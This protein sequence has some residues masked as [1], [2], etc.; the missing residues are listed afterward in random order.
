MF[1]IWILGGKGSRE[2]SKWNFSP[3][4]RLIEPYFSRYVHKKGEG[5]PPYSY[6]S[7]KVGA[8]D[9]AGKTL[10]I[11]RK[12]EKTFLTMST[13][14]GA[15]GAVCSHVVKRYIFT[16]SQIPILQFCPFFCRG[17]PLNN[18]SHSLHFLW[19]ISITGF[20]FHENSVIRPFLPSGG[21]SPG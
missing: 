12:K 6:V 3:K 4:G 14:M 7:E 15:G 5:G 21:S 17:E 13:Q 16:P 9:N 19:I 11:G 18:L 1:Q 10:W 2:I 20:I 8:F